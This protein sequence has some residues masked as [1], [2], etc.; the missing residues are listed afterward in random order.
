[1]RDKPDHEIKVLFIIQNTEETC[2]EGVGHDLHQIDLALRKLE[3]LH[4]PDTIGAM[5]QF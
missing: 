2:N 3:I 5:P 4:R 1:M